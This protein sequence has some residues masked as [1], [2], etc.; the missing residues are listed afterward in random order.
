VRLGPFE[1]TR[2][3]LH[4]EI[5]VTFR[6]AEAERSSIVAHECDTFGRVDRSGAEMAGFDSKRVRPNTELFQGEVVYLILAQ[7]EPERYEDILDE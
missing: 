1:F 3:T 5:L 6:A 2:L 4:F 7:F